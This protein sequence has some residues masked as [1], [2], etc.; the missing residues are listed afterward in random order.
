MPLAFNFALEYAITKVQETNMELDMNGTHN[1]LTYAAD[2]NLID[3]IRTI[4][5]NEYLLLNYYKDI[6]L[7]VKHRE[8]YVHESRMMSKNDSKWA[9]HGG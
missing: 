6:C 5:R 8:N 7:T 9:Y 1:I 4:E 3:D 2:V